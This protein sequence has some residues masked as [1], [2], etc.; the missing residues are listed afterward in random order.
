M[1]SWV[2]KTLKSIANVRHRHIMFSIPEEFRQLFYWNR[3]FLQDLADMATATIIEVLTTQHKRRGGKRKLFPGVIAVI[4]TF[5]RDMKWNPHVRVL[6]AEEAIDKKSRKFKSFAFMSYKGFRKVWQYKL[7]NFI[8]KKFK[9]N[10]RVVRQVEECWNE[11]S[12]GLYV[13]LKEPMKSAGHA[14]R[15]LGRYLGKPAIAQ[16]R[17][18][19]Y[20]GKN[21]TFWY[22][23][24]KSGQRKYMTLQAEQF[25]GRLVMHIPEKNF[26][27]VRRYGFY[28]RHVSEAI[29]AMVEATRRMVQQVF[30]FLKGEKKSWRMR[31]IESFQRDPLKCPYCGDE[32]ELWEIWHPVYGQ[33]YDFYRDA[34][35]YVPKEKT[36]KTTQVKKEEEKGSQLLFPFMA[37]IRTSV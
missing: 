1:D 13:H 25:I 35:T 14:A 4:H 18:V 36:N 26:Q 3:E 16:Y 21:V 27:M 17:I 24:H 11:K 12:D 22:D 34:P 15:Y 29:K 9:G 19:K 20:D 31:L 28:A 2:E 5:G 23:D 7:L 30:D 32:M 8:K 33:I 10:A 37:K 6:V